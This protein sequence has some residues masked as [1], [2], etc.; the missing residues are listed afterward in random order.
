LDEQKL[1]GLG[2]DVS[3]LM[4]AD[5]Q[6]TISSVHTIKTTYVGHLEDFQAPTGSVNVFFRA[7]KDSAKT[8]HMVR[9][10]VQHGQI[11][12]RIKEGLGGR[13]VGVVGEKGEAQSRRGG[14]SLEIVLL[15]R[16]RGG[17]LNRAL[18]TEHRTELARF[19][20][21]IALRFCCEGQQLTRSQERDVNQLDTFD[22]ESLGMTVLKSVPPKIRFKI[23]KTEKELI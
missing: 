3:H 23:F 19:F 8:Y 7:G 21:Q 5:C 18:C 2:K 1:K 14:Q 4:Q 22:F 17:Q 12:K 10:K 9:Q 11:P 20:P 13:P 6:L 15:P 16:K